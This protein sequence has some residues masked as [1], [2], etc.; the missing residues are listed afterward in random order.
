MDVK[1]LPEEELA[2]RIGQ[3]RNF[4]V[5]T[6]SFILLLLHLLL[7]HCTAL[8]LLEAKNCVLLSRILQLLALLVLSP[9][10]LRPADLLD[11]SCEL[12]GRLRSNGLNVPLLRKVA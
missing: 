12:F 5:K 2:L 7:L 11:E 4:G 10:L 9:V 6:L 8:L 3:L 1:Q